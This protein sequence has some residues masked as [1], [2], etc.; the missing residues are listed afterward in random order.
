L[1]GAGDEMMDSASFE[2]RRGVGEESILQGYDTISLGKQFH[3]FEG[4]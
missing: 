3:C 2:V 1:L 4:Q